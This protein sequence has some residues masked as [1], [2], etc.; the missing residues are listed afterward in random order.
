MIINQLTGKPEMFRHLE[1]E[2]AIRSKLSQSYLP[3]NCIPIHRPYLVELG[4]GIIAAYT[5]AI[6]SRCEFTMAFEL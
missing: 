2:S 3:D 1:Y 6:G 5:K 4:F